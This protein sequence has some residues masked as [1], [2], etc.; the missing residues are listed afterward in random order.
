HDF[1]QY[2]YY[3]YNLVSPVIPYGNSAPVFNN[4]VTNIT[5]YEDV[6]AYSP[7]TLDSLFYDPDGDP[8]TFI[9]YSPCSATL[10]NNLSILLKPCSNKNGY[11]GDLVINASD[12][13]RVT[14]AIIP[15]YAIPVND[16]P[17]PVEPQRYIFMLANS[18]NENTVLGNCFVDPDGDP[19][20]YSI[21]SNGSIEAT[22]LQNGTLRLKAPNDT[23]SD[24][25]VIINASD[26]SG[27]SCSMII[28]VTVATIVN[29]PPTVNESFRQSLTNLTVPAGNETIF[30]WS[31]S[32][33]F[34]DNENDTLYFSLISDDELNAVIKEGYLC[35]YPLVNASSIFSIGIKARDLFSEPIIAWLNVSVYVPNRP[36]VAVGQIPE[37]NMTPSSDYYTPFSIE[38][39]FYDP[40]EG[41]VCDLDFNFTLPPSLHTLSNTTYLNITVLQDG[42]LYLKTLNAPAGS[43]DVII[44]ASDGE[45]NATQILPLII[46]K[47][48]TPPRITGQS[49]A[50]GK[51]TVYEGSWANFS[52][53]AEDTDNDTIKYRWYLDDVVVRDGGSSTYQLYLNYSMA[54]NYT[55]RVEIRSNK[56]MVPVEWELVVYDKNTVPVAVIISP[57]P[58]DTDVK[59]YDNKPVELRG[60]VSDEDGDELIS[61]WELD[62]KNAGS[63]LILLVNLS[64]GKHEA[65]LF[66]SDGKHT[67]TATTKFEVLSSTAKSNPVWTA[68]FAILAIAGLI[69]IIYLGYKQFLLSKD[70][71]AEDW[72]DSEELNEVSDDED[73]NKNIEKEDSENELSKEKANNK[74]YSE[75]KNTDKNYLNKKKNGMKNRK[76]EIKEAKKENGK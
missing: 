35:V 25:L 54:G 14:S 12:G 19:L 36:V 8:I 67:G 49:P 46:Y 42:F 15:I 66:V 11:L 24:E 38:S 40:D 62:G 27:L 18:L 6:P 68:V 43:F 23:I 57:D 53:L 29:Y 32:S 75:P 71:A 21:I 22:I 30:N 5:V 63:G 58:S 74:S 47:E 2:E 34:T 56:S 55:V 59:L 65:T 64:K 37:I 20:T 51:V 33:L 69:I 48:D 16:P 73:V 45:F 1:S 44:N 4:T 28:H 61:Y 60:S 17:H 31:V 52:V 3:T 76:K 9:L 10:M 50:F 26:P 72:N 13:Y 7:F 39:F 41:C 70:A